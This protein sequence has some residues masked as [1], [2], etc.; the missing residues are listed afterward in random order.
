[1]TSTDD[2][3][4][5]DGTGNNFIALGDGDYTAFL[6]PWWIDLPHPI[7]SI[8]GAFQGLYLWRDGQCR[9]PGAK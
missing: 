8:G 7:F 4:I 3:Y 2:F 6:N 5:A 1:M 9:L